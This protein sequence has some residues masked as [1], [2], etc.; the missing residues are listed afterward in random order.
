M[1]NN[2]QTFKSKVAT[3]LTACGIE[4]NI[5]SLFR[6]MAN[7]L[8]QC[9]PLAVL[10]LYYEGASWLRL[11]RCNSAY[12]L[13][14]WNGSTNSEWSRAT[15]RLVATVLTAC[16]I[17]T[18]FS[19]CKNSSRPAIV[20]TVLTAC[21]IETTLFSQRTPSLGPSSCNSAYRLRYWNSVNCILTFNF[22]SSCNSA[23]R[24]RY[25]NSFCSGP[26]IAMSLSLR[27]NSAYR[28]RYWNSPR[29][30]LP[31]IANQCGLQQH[32]PLAVCITWIVLNPER[33][34]VTPKS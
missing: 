10:K 9:L 17:E 4:T 25:W 16:G 8:Q 30:R 33:I 28:L 24:L 15:Y 14:Y 21:G 27:C 34:V 31:H 3:V 18:F 5:A 22:L 7:W 12:R 26:A 23:Y 13:R 19:S 29:K 20:A 2:T 32:L 11:R 1:A 6:D